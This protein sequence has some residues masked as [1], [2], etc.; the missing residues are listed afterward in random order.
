MFE[1]LPFLAIAKRKLFIVRNSRKKHT[2]RYPSH[3]SKKNTSNFILKKKNLKTSSPKPQASH[4]LPRTLKPLNQNVSQ[5]YLES[6][7]RTMVGA[8][9]SPT[10]TNKPT[11]QR[12]DNRQLRQLGTSSKVNHQR[13]T[14]FTIHQDILNRIHDHHIVPKRFCH[15]KTCWEKKTLGYGGKMN[16]Q[17]YIYTFY[18]GYLFGIVPT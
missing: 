13:F 2:L 17:P 16:N 14:T 6:R 7:W 12:V 15:R 10:P 4:N 1:V 3:S 18:S 5:L 9:L 8:F 11:N